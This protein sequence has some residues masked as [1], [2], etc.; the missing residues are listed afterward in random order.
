M[1]ISRSE[2]QDRKRTVL[3]RLCWIL[4]VAVAAISPF[5]LG[6]DSAVFI[7]WY[8]TF[9]VLSLIFFPLSSM[10]F[11]KNRD[12]GYAFSK[13]LSMA[14]SGFAMWT[15]SYLHI[16][17]FRQIVIIILLF[18]FASVFIGL[19][20]PRESFM[21]ALDNP[22]T[23]RLMAFEEGLFAAGMLFWSYVRGLKPVLDSLEKPM[24][25]GFMMSLMRTDFLPAKDMW[26]SAGDINYYYF[27]QY[28]YTFMTKLSDLH[29]EVTYNL[30]MG[31]TFALT[32]ILSFAVVYMLIELGAKKGL[33]LFKAAPFAGGIAAAIIT[34]L[35][36][37]SHSFF[38]G[39]Y[40]DSALSKLVKAP[41]YALLKFLNDKGL[42]DK[43]TPPAADLVGNSDSR[44]ITIDSFWFANSTRYIGYNPT[45]HDKTIHEFPYYS[46]LVAD[47]HAHLINLAFVLLIIGLAIVLVNSERTERTAALF[48]KTDMVLERSN[49]RNWLKTETMTILKSLRVNITDP[50]FLIIAML[51]GIFMMCN[52]WDFAI[53][54]VVISMALLIS[55]LK[56]YG[57]LGSWETLPIFLFQLA[58]VMVPFLFI[59]N[60][61]LAVAGY[62]I[63]VM[64]SFGVMLLSS[65]SFT[66]TGA[67]ISLL[68][69]IS[70]LLILPFNWN[71][72]PMAKSLALSLDRTPL[73]QLTMLWGTHILVGSLFVMY[74]IIRRFREK[75]DIQAAAATARGPVS[76]FF[77]GMNTVDLFAA[78]LF[79]CGSLFVLLPELVY[80]VDIY[81]GHKRANTMFKF[82]YQAFVMLS[83]V[84]GY[85]ISRLA[86]TKPGKSKVDR[87]W[88]F[89]SVFMI[90]LMIVPMY[91]TQLSTGQWIGKLDRAN[92]KGLDGVSGLP[93]PDV[94]AAID[95]INE[96]IDGQPVLLESYGDSY[97]EYCRLTAFTGLRTIVGWQTHVWLWRTSKNVNGYGDIVAPMQSVVR[98]IYEYTD[99]AKVAG[100][101]DKY[102]VEYIAVGRNERTK[103][104]NINEDML[105]KLGPV[106]YSNES[107][108]I[109]KVE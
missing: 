20:K 26:Y 94:V 45:T 7:R 4:P 2:Q 11:S 95:W 39:S 18:A 79:I 51:L 35:G 36:G 88:S 102:E 41:G 60:P 83:L 100:Y 89:V 92:Y 13:P 69:F 49:D 31:T 53:Y 52:F 108:Y 75:D 6:S 57:K 99:E 42:L 77:L 22:S 17:P 3:S 64:L 109:I 8:I 59:P 86:L 38:Y 66:I 16:L 12:R 24:D 82:T 68:F 27:G 106:I 61:L 85:A 81:G 30:S 47:L 84:M 74:L 29:P 107:L 9:F 97:T 21:D 63:A 34:T 44:P 98:S 80:V 15:F 96:N 19:R 50:V 73:F 101:L 103:F 93:S 56:G 58:V 76:R 37:N 65:D 105:K 10:I 87:N 48:R 78:G 91:Y 104:P 46:F 5:Y 23:V 67:Q 70:H 33:K 71:F 43:W 72:D 14:I 32:L 55:N 40:Y 62:A 90:I 28:I 1:K 25:Y 54:L